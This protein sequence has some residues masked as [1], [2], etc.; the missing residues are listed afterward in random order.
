MPAF[1]STLKA[2]KPRMALCKLPM[3]IQPVCEGK[4]TFKA[5]C[6]HAHSEQACM[7][8]NRGYLQTKVH[9]A[10]A[11][12]ASHNQPAAEQCGDGQQTD[13]TVPMLKTPCTNLS[14]KAQAQGT[15]GAPCQ[16]SQRQMLRRLRTVFVIAALSS[17]QPN[18]CLVR[19]RLSRLLNKAE[20][21]T[22]GTPTYTAPPGL[23]KPSFGRLHLRAAFP[24]CVSLSLLRR[25][26]GCVADQHNVSTQSEIE[27]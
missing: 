5:E 22:S 23:R 11:E 12:E 9:V 25:H 19:R 21:D 20:A 3:E 1:C 17:A 26:D 18:S 16:R 2:P 8:M 14:A 13:C 7:Q 27:L 24:S 6:S 4:F 15:Y 10:E